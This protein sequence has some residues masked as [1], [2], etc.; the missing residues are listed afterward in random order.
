VSAYGL[1]HADITDKVYR[2]LDLSFNLL[3]KVPA[4]QIATLKQLKTLYFIQNKISRIDGLESLAETLESIEFGGN[5]LR[6][7]TL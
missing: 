4:A 3:R 5:K 2:S 7:S 1:R 6:V